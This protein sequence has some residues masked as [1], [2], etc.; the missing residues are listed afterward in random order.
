VLSLNL[1]GGYFHDDSSSP[2]N[3]TYPICCL[4]L[5]VDVLPT[6]LHIQYRVKG[7]LLEPHERD[8]MIFIGASA[9]FLPSGPFLSWV[10]G[11][12]IAEN[13]T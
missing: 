4:S 11:R 1:L 12:L 7:I 10:E 5:F 13:T 2:I 6:Q 9:F 3:C 8:Y